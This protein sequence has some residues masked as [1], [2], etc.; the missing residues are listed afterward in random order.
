[1]NYVLI[2]FHH[3]WMRTCCGMVKEHPLDSFTR[4]HS[5]EK[6][7]ILKN[8]S[9]KQNCLVVLNKTAPSQE[10]LN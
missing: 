4:K 2:P 3:L 6:K 10:N 1:M 7:M 9:D 8:Y 5:K